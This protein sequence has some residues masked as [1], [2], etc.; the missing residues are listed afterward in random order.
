MDLSAERLRAAEALLRGVRDGD[1]RNGPDDSSHNAALA[2]LA[3]LGYPDRK[4]CESTVSQIIRELS[5][6][7]ENAETGFFY[8]Y[9]RDDDF[10][11]PKGAFVICSFWIAQALARL[12]R[13]TEARIILDRVLAAAN[14]VGL[15]SEHFVHETSTQCGNFPQAYS[16][17]GLINAAFAVSLPWSD[18]L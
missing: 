18:V 15:F 11:K 1:V 7:Q 5:L 8:R 12:G 9:V 13:G 10:G 4:L 2:Q 3:I 16:H 14:Y 6:K 17:V